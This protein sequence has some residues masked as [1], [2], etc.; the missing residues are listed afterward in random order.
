MTVRW[1][2]EAWERYQTLPSAHQEQAR[3]LLP[4]LLLLPPAGHAWYRT[5]NQQMVSLVTTYDGQAVYRIV[6]GTWHDRLFVLD[7][8]VFPRNAPAEAV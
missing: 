8:L 1:L 3:R 6:Y 4:A 2:P 5:L 7:V